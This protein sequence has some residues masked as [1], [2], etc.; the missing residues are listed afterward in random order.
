MPENKDKDWKKIDRRGKTSEIIHSCKMVD[1]TELYGIFRILLKRK[2]AGENPFDP[3][4][5][6]K[7]P[8]REHIQPIELERIFHLFSDRYPDLVATMTKIME[9]NTEI[10][11][12]WGD[13]RCACPFPFD[14][15]QFPC[16]TLVCGNDELNNGY[17]FRRS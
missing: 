4:E 8:R 17:P 7:D 5:Q 1:E 10:S 6:P 2:L 3:N 12:Y 15:K 13:R 16:E 9:K 11:P 14:C